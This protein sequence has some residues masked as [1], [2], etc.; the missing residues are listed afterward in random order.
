MLQRSDRSECLLTLRFCKA[1][2]LRHRSGPA[3]DEVP[4]LRFASV[5]SRASQ[6]RAGG[7]T[8]RL[9]GLSALTGRKRSV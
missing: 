1:A 2:P 6:K 9:G 3:L 5:V 8:W 4:D 7:W